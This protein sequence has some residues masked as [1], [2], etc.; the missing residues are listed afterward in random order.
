MIVSRH[1]VLR[2]TRPL[3]EVKRTRPFA[4]VRFCGRYLG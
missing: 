1:F 3:S 4:E 2:R